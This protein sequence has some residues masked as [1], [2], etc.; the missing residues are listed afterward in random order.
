MP[1]VAPSEF[2]TTPTA[3]AFGSVAEAIIQA[4]YLKD[5]GRVS[6]F[7][8]SPFDFIDIS[9]GF[10]NS[11]LYIAFLGANNPRLSTSQL[12]VLSV[13]GDLK[14]PDIM[15]HNPPRRTE[16]YEI[17]PNS[18]TGRPAGATKVALI[19]AVMSA[20]SLPYVPGIQYTPNKKISIFSG[21]PLGARLDVFFH[22]Q[23][24]APGLIVY[25]ICAEG[26]LE[27]LGLAALLAIL[28]VIILIMLKGRAPGG[29][30]IPAPAIA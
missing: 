11:I 15:T 20:F 24:I 17:K 9:H 3:S 29:A 7:P 22:F 6:F 8:A 10:G 18:L 2:L 19:A 12:A 14:I 16:Y 21:T 28:A 27:K 26:E 25:E 30:P 23:R 13:G 5:V 1:C 4:D